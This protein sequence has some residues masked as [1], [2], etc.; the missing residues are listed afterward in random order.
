MAV[1]K[2]VDDGISLLK[3]LHYDLALLDL[4]AFDSN[5]SVAIN[6]VLIKELAQWNNQ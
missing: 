1:D 4:Y 6:L 3:A 5:I 2:S